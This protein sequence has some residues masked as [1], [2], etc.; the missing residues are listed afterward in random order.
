MTTT[1]STR[2]GSTK[3]DSGK[4]DDS[5]ST[6]DG[7][8]MVQTLKRTAKEFSQDNCTD[9]A[10]ALT[11]YAI[12]ALFPALIA[13]VGIM[14]LVMDPTTLT[15]GIKTIFKE[16]SPGSDTKSIQD[17]ISNI[18]KSRGTGAVMLV[19]GIF[20]AIW[21]ASGYVGAFSRASNALYEQ[22]EGRKFF[23]LKPLQLLVTLMMVLLAALVL[24]AL[25]VSGPLSSAL[26]SAL[27]IGN[28]GETVFS[29]VKW[30]VMA[31]IVL[32]ML[33]VLYYFGPNAKIPKFAWITRGS[34][35]ALVIWA[36]ASAAFG[37]YVANFGSYNKTYGA[38]GGVISFLVWIWITNLAVLFGQQLNAELERTREL[39]HG[40]RKAL[41]Q[42]QLD[43]RD[44]PSEKQLP[45]TAEGANPPPSAMRD[46]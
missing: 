16:V 22:A 18:T 43:P 34:V 21:S 45:E 23:K 4:S 3:S 12:L 15:D 40:D 42:I 35:A 46:A 19:L 26:A 9:W 11:Y 37:F 8:S 1:A 33:S 27:H 29:V 38:L 25:V 2:S 36:V 31:A 39:K 32:L 28:T 17:A 13:L 14:G 7:T 6:P 44:E 10:A 20:G 30:P 41:D 24:I 5:T